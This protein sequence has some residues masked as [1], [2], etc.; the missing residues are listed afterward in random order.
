MA[1]QLLQSLPNMSLAISAT[2]IAC[3]AISFAALF[4]LYGRAKT[5][6]IKFGA[7]D[8]KLSGELRTD[9]KKCKQDSYAQML[10]AR[11]KKERI[12]KILTDVLFIIVILAVGALTIFSLVLRTKGE[13]VFLGDTAYL[14]V[15]TPSMEDKNDDNAFLKDNDDGVRIQQYALIG[16]DK[17]DPADLKTGDIIAFN[18]DENSVFVHRII[19]IKESDGKRLFTTMGDNNSISAANETNISEDRIVGVFNGFH[20]AHLGVLLI[21]MRSDIGLVGLIFTFLLLAVIDSTSAIITRATEKRQQQLAGEIDSKDACAN[22][23]A[24][25]KTDNAED[26]TE[27]K[28]DNADTI[29]ESK[30]DNADAIA[31]SKADGADDIAESKADNADTIA[32]STDDGTDDGDN[33]RYKNMIDSDGFEPSD[34]F[35]EYADRADYYGLGNNND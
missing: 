15:L 28:A 18:Y 26:I 4:F 24:E 21:Y 25:S 10:S 3:M 32:E 31:E 29:A 2:V 17:V 11:K 5:N 7:E 13:Q 35:S 20:S 6:A 8:E 22:I 16:V 23:L 34:G 30:T 1:S 14:T 12:I 9:F 27:N 33:S 19:E